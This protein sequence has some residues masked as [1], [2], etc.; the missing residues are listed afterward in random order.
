MVMNFNDLGRQMSL[1]CHAIS[2]LWKDVLGLNEGHDLLLTLSVVGA[3]PLK[4]VMRKVDEIPNRLTEQLRGK[5]ELI[6]NA[7][8]PSMARIHTD[9]PP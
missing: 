5:W 2:G 4:A 9:L 1:S 8:S 6:Q 7:V 3:L